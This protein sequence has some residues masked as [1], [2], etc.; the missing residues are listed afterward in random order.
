MKD[1]D[2]RTIHEPPSDPVLHGSSTINVG[3]MQEAWD[4]E[5]GTGE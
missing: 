2:R 3:P 5:D 1:I 4:Y